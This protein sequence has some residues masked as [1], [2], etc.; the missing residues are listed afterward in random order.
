LC[1]GA[2]PTVREVQSAAVPAERNGS[3]LHGVES[4]CGGAKEQLVG[5]AIDWAP[6]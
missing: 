6:G 2:L 1:L 4:F 3:S 5:D